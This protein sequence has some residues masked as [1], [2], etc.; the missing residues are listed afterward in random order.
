MT[1][2]FWL[3]L[4]IIFTIIE[5]TAPALVTVWFAIA[6]ALT[7]P[8]SFFTNDPKIDIIFFTIISVLSILFIR[9]Y[10]KKCL[11]RNHLNSDATIIDTA[12]IITKIIDV[13]SKEKTYEVRYKSS[14][15]TAISSDVFELDD[16]ARIV[17]FKGNKIIINKVS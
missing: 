7:I 17:S 14:I 13:K 8:V 12:V 11:N 10:A 16:S 6:S 9:P 3:V 15:W 1:Y 2:I 5:F 4:T